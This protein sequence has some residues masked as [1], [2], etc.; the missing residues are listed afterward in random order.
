MTIQQVIEN[1]PV[2]S[3]LFHVEEADRA[4]AFVFARRHSHAVHLLRVALPLGG[5]LTALALAFV[6]FAPRAPLLPDSVSVD[7]IST[8]GS[9]MTMAHPKLSGYR[10]DGRPFALT[11]E[12]AVQDLAHPTQATLSGVAGTMTL[13]DRLA[14]KLTAGEGVYDN[15][16]QRL[17]VK[18]A[19]KLT[20]DMFE[21]TL[22]AADI[23]FRGGALTSDRPVRVVRGDGSEIKADAFAAADNGRELTFSGH[24]QSTFA[25]I[26]DA[27][28]GDSH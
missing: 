6:A 3:A 1:R 23:D 22:D 16:T 8:D 28:R 5:L 20:S 9:S 12:K 11:A 25:S 10:R 4:R 15:A 7:S 21:L 17:A 13:S 18:N 19:V 14:V 2:I 24:V 26:D 27:G